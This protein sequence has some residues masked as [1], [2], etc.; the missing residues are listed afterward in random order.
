MEAFEGAANGVSG[1]EWNQMSGYRTAI[2]GGAAEMYMTPQK[3]SRTA[4]LF[5]TG[6]LFDFSTRKVLTYDEHGKVCK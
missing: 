4:D 6:G 1:Y 5:G 2:G 3:H